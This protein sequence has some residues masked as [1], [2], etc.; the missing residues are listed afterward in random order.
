MEKTPKIEA[1][2]VPITLFDNFLAQAIDELQRAG[3][4]SAKKTYKELKIESRYAIS[5]I[6]HSFLALDSLINYLGFE[7]FFSSHPEPDVFIDETERSY[8][9]KHVLKLWRN[10][11]LSVLE[12]IDLILAEKKLQPLN[13]NTVLKIKELNNLRNW[14]VHGKPYSMTLYAENVWEGLWLHST[15]KDV[16]DD[17][18]KDKFPITKFNS[19]AN[20]NKNDAKTALIIVLEVIT[21]IIPN[22]QWFHPTI[23]TFHGGEKQHWLGYDSTVET[24]IQEFNLE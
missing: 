17:F 5:S 2:D 12:K 4:M 21:F 15:L 1:Y 24:L 16:E 23:V 9:L 11:R 3:D 6:I 22:F 14:V 18:G 19:P 10:Q 8:A 13:S 7:L 20:L